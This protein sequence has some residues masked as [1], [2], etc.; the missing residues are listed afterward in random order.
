MEVV[1]IAWD[2]LDFM[3]PAT[4]IIG[5]IRRQRRWFTM[6]DVGTYGQ[7]SYG[8]VFQEFFRV[9]TGAKDPRFTTASCPARY[10]NAKSYVFLGD[11]AFPLHENLMRPCPGMLIIY[12]L[13]LISLVTA[14]MY[15]PLYEKCHLFFKAFGKLYG[16]FWGMGG[17]HLPIQ[18][19][20]FIF[21]IFYIVE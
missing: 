3:Y 11:A 18:G 20:F 8:G 15:A 14:Y 4:H 9:Q 16:V 13:F 19:F 5:A 10:H 7:E 1:R 21:N 6:V 17:A 2:L 12:F